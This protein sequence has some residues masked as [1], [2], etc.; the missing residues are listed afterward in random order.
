MNL[1]TYPVNVAD[2]QGELFLRICGR[3]IRVKSSDPWK[4]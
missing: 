4:I 1:G 3:N 2:E